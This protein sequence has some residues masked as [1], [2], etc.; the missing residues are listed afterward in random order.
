MAIIIVPAISSGIISY[1]PRFSSAFSAIIVAYIF[2]IVAPAEEIL[3]RGIIQSTLIKKI[4]IFRGIILTS[5][6]FGL[7]HLPN[8]ALGI[9]ISLW[10]WKLALIAMIAGLI[11]GWTYTRTKSIWN[12]AI[13]HGILSSAYF[14]FLN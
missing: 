2:I 3:F 8:G 6:I 11:L 9:N 5:I 1:Y 7:A 14:I 12:A 4:G 13:L 10:N